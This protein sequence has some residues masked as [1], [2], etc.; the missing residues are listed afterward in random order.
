MISIGK[1]DDKFA[2]VVYKPIDL[3]VVLGLQKLGRDQVGFVAQELVAILRIGWPNVCSTVVSV[4]D[5]L[6]AITALTPHGSFKS[7]RIFLRDDIPLL[8]G[9]EM[10]VVVAVQIDILEMPSEGCLP[11]SQVEVSGIDTWHFLAQ[12]VQQ[13]LELRNIPAP[14]GI[15]EQRARHIGAIHGIVEIQALPIRSLELLTTFWCPIFLVVNAVVEILE[16]L[17][18]KHIGLISAVMLPPG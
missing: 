8:G 9:S 13:I 15:A 17:L 10:N 2:L 16:T 4:K 3:D 7:P 11:H 5:M 18:V 1:R 14:G 12:H 6:F